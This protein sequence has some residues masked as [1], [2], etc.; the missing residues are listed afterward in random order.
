[1]TEDPVKPL[2]AEIQQVLEPVATMSPRPHAVSSRL[3]RKEEKKVVKQTLMI[4]GLAVVMLIAF[5]FLVIPGLIRITV[6]ILGGNTTGLGQ[7]D[8]IPPQIPILAAPFEATA[9]TQISLTGYGEAGSTI[10]ALVNETQQKE[11]KAQDDG[12]FAIEIDLT[13]G[14]NKVAAFAKDTAGNESDVSTTYS[15][16]LDATAPKIELEEPQ[17]GQQY[18]LRKNQMM[19]IK[20][21]SEAGAKIYVNG[22]LT[23]ARED[24]TFSTTYQLHEGENK[25]QFEAVDKAGNTTQHEVT[26]SFR[27]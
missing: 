15:V 16:A 12:S 27:L 2:E 5:V 7:E 26:V 3:V 4:L 8:T 17:D 11:V 23:V 22:R 25:L 18:E 20:G 9:S 13:Q 21:T 19:T 10:V 14:E 24:G 6:A 1:M